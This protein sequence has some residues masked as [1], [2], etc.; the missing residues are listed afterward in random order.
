MLDV[1]NIP[2]GYRIPQLRKCLLEFLFHGRPVNLSGMKKTFLNDVTE[3]S[4]IHLCKHNFSVYFWPNW[5]ING[6]KIFG[7]DIPDPAPGSSI[8]NLT[9]LI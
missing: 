4:Q 8:K 9:L 1:G 2:V 5:K 6:V 7:H 3:K